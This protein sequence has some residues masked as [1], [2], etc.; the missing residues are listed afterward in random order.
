[1]SDGVPRCPAPGA[2]RARRRATS[3]TG[4]S[5]LGAL[6]DVEQSAKRLGAVGFIRKPFEL[7]DVVSEVGRA[8]S[9]S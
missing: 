3:S 2:I 7:D 9:G 4:T 5:V 8:M 1:M 6:K